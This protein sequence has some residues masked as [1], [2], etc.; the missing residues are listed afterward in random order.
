MF[1][2][3]QMIPTLLNHQYS[4]SEPRSWRNKKYRWRVNRP[5]Q[6]HDTQPDC[7]FP[8]FFLNNNYYYYCNHPK[9][10]SYVHQTTDSCL[11][12][13]PKFLNIFLTRH[14]TFPQCSPSLYLS[15][16]FKHTALLILIPKVPILPNI[17]SSEAGY[18]TTKQIF[19]KI[20]YS[21]YLP[22][23]TITFSRY[24]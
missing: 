10:I 17:R 22:T 24:R 1:T 8:P 18:I 23:F 11:W 3:Y 2:F 9:Q 19:Y 13:F 4:R 5:T 16:G 15:V 12:F 7:Y 6:W 21:N 14:T 20:V